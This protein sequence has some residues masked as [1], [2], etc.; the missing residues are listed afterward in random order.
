MIINTATA[1]VPLLMAFLIRNTRLPCGL[2]APV[3][4]PRPI[5]RDYDG[6]DAVGN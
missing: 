2:N 3:F 4:V 5:L 6:T 1:I